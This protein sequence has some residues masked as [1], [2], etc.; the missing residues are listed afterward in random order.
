MLNPLSEL[1][2]WGAHGLEHLLA[3]G[4]YQCTT[5]DA[6]IQEILAQAQEWL[7]GAGLSHMAEIKPGGI[8]VHWRGLPDSEIK[9]VKARTCERWNRFTGNHE[10]RLLEFD[11]GI[12]LRITH[13]D[14]GDAISAVLKRAD[15]G[16]P[17]AFLG[18]DLTDEDAFRVLGEWGLS[19]LVRPEYRKTRAN[20][21]LRPPQELI[22]FLRQWSKALSV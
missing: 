22:R 4:T 3:D 18:D 12:E 19:I 13:P 9:R 2:I 14:K 20:A 11:G 21:W 6:S 7:H 16:A 8:A 15:P 17:V 1:E 5:I 10:L